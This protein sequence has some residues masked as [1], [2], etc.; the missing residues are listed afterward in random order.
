[1]PTWDEI[2]PFTERDTRNKWNAV[3][4]L[5]GINVAGLILPAVLQFAKVDALD[6][7]IPFHLDSGIK[8]GWIWQFFTY[9]FWHPPGLSS[10]NVG[11]FWAL[12]AFAFGC[13]ILHTLGRELEQEWGWRRF[14][15]FY[16]AT[17]V[18]GAVVHAFYQAVAP[19]DVPAIDFLGPTLAVM[20]V[21]GLRWPD[22]RALLFFFFPM[23]LLTMALIM[24]GVVVLFTLSGFHTGITPVATLG[25]VAAAFAVFKL[26]PRLDSWLDAREQRAARERFLDEFE[27]K[28][29]VDAILDKINKQGMD[30]LS[31]HERKMLKRASKL[32]ADGRDE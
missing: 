7:I 10:N 28:R 17:G 27:L 3:N 30:S 5:I 14:T 12:L 6:A 24:I 32:Y 21:A 20:L 2:T 31:S 29:Q 22:R 26:E 19:S 4:V 25:S 16:V 23:R 13:W 9:T 8:R 18:Y 1:M 15:V 11:L